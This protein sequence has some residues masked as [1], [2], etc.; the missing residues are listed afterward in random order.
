[1]SYEV[2]RDTSDKILKI[3]MANSSIWF[4]IGTGKREGLDFE[5]NQ[6]TNIYSSLFLFSD[7]RNNSAY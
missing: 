6:P 5:L 2:A 1:M 7:F 4:R 3:M